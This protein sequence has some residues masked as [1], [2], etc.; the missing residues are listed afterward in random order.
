MCSHEVIG[1]LPAGVRFP[2]SD[3]E[4]WL[5]MRLDPAKTDSA[6]FDYQAIARLRDDVSIDAAAADLQRLLPRLPDEFPGRMTRRVNRAD[7]HA[8]IGASAR[9]RCRRGYR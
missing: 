9:S 2:A 6:T 8:R 4:L 1:I 7:T 3:T 5:P